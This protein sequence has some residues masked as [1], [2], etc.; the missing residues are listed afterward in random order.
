MLA[1]TDAEYKVA[2][3]HASQVDLFVFTAVCERW[4]RL[5]L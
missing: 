5:L 4:V 2:P 3:S 1:D